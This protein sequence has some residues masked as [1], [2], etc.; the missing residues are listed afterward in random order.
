MRGSGAV[1]AKSLRL[2]GVL[3]LPCLAAAGLRWI[4]GTFGVNLPV[5]PRRG[6]R[7]QAFWE[8]FR[9][10]LTSPI[11]RRSGRFRPYR[12]ADDLVAPTEF[13]RREIHRVRSGGGR[14]M[15]DHACA[16]GLPLGS[17]LLRQLAEIPPWAVILPTHRCRIRHGWLCGGE[18]G[19][20]WPRAGSRCSIPGGAGWRVPTGCHWSDVGSGAIAGWPSLV[21]WR[22][23]CGRHCSGACSCRGSPW[24]GTAGCRGWRQPGGIPSEHRRSTGSAS[25]W[26]TMAAAS[27]RG[28]AS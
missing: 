6:P 18:T 24:H 9:T 2:G 14:R 28:E 12:G 20:E 25:R 13:T 22:R 17:Q 1:M 5:S 27:C 10:G 19:S 15:T 8:G 16:S 23:Q 26:C 7:L 3:A 21:R 4:R 11:E